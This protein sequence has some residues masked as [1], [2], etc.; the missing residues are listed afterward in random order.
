MNI[1]VQNCGQNVYKS[2]RVSHQGSCGEKSGNIRLFYPQN[3]R[4][5]PVSSSG[6]RTSRAPSQWGGQRAR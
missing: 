6:V 1:F 2:Q 3:C 4:S 5:S